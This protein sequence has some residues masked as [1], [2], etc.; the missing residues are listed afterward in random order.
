MKTTLEFSNRWG[1][2][3]RLGISADVGLS[4]GLNIHVAFL[5]LFDIRLNLDPFAEW[6]PGVTFDVGILSGDIC[7][8]WFKEEDTDDDVGAGN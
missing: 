8:T 7:L 1:D 3:L 4:Y 6:M 2:L 5:P